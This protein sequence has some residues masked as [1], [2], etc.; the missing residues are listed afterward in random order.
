MTSSLLQ[1]II[2][3]GGGGLHVGL[4]LYKPVKNVCVSSGYVESSLQATNLCFRLHHYNYLDVIISK[5]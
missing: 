3:G 4:L 5:G 2:D 1:L